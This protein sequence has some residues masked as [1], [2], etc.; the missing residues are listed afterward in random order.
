[1]RALFLVPSGLGIYSTTPWRT[2][3][4]TEH[5]RADGWKN[6]GRTEV[7]RTGGRKIF[8][9]M[10]G[11]CFG[12]EKWSQSHENHWKFRLDTCTRM[13]IEHF[14]SCNTKINICREFV[15]KASKTDAPKWWNFGRA[16]P[17]GSQIDPRLIPKARN[18]SVRPFCSS[19]LSQHDVRMT[20]FG[21]E[22]PAT[23]H[24]ISL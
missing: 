14:A 24:G 23:S 12:V 3:G 20:A 7:V 9:R 21:C 2:D 13:C 16:G 11:K 5:F 6:F 17:P 4:R 15:P 10:D 1:M 19:K 8:G 18:R 22:I